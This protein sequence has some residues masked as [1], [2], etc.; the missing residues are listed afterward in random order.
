MAPDAPAIEVLLAKLSL[1]GATAV[2]IP[3]KDKKHK[4]NTIKI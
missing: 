1:A 3:G 2:A 4:T